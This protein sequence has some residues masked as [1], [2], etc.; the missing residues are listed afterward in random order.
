MDLGCYPCD[1]IR[2]LTSDGHGKAANIKVASAKG[3]RLLTD[4]E[5]DLSMT[6]ELEILT[7]DDIFANSSVRDPVRYG[8]ECSFFGP[9]GSSYWGGSSTVDVKLIGSERTV[10]SGAFLSLISLPFIYLPF[11]VSYQQSFMMTISYFLFFIAFSI[12]L[13]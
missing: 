2:F 10:R 7:D 1:I 8:I 5:I 9:V 13:L 3:E 4:P 11:S 6:A 12:M